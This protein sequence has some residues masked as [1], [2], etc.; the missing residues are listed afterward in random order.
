MT[1]AALKQFR[2]AFLR[3]VAA[4]RYETS[5]WVDVVMR[6]ETARFGGTVVKLGFG[7]IPL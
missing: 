3:R 6:A 2:A 1:K 7:E 5:V 4:D